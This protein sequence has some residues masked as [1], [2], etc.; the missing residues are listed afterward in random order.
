MSSCC[1]DAGGG[2]CDRRAFLK[3][4]GAGLAAAGAAP[5]RVRRDLVQLLRR[6]D[7]YV[8]EDKGLSTA[9]FARLRERGRPVWYAGDE[10]ETI[11]M[12]VGG[13]CA[14]QLY[15]LGDG[16]LGCWDLANEEAN[17]GY[18]RV[19]YRRGRS[20]RL[21]VRGGDRLVP[22]TAP[23]Q[24]FLLRWRPDGAGGALRERRLDRE[25]FPGVR[26]RGEYPLGFV[27]YRHDDCPLAAELT[28]F[29]PFVPLRAAD[30]SFPATVLRWRLRND[31][32]EPLEVE[33]T[34]WLENPVLLR[35]RAGRA[36]R[37]VQEEFHRR[38]LR[39]L[40][41]RAEEPPPAAEE[42]PPLLFADF[43]GADYGDWEVSGEAFG[44]GPARGTLPNQQPVDGYAGQGLVNSFLG[45]DDRLQGRLRSPEFRIERPW[46]SLLVGGGGHEGRTEVR[47]LVGD[48]I[49]RRARGENRE[50][51]E[52]RNWDVA[53][54]R[55]RS[56]RIE[57]VDLESGGWG[58]INVDR[59]EFRDAPAP[60]GGGPL[61]EQPDFGQVVLAPLGPGEPRLDAA[62][63]RATASLRLAPGEERETVFVLAWHFPNLRNAGRPVGRSYAAAFPDAVAVAAHLAAE[64][65]R[66]EAATRRWHATFYDSTLP[67]WLLDRIG[68]TVSILATATCQRWRD[69]RFWGWEGAGCC[70]GTCGHVWNYAH[71][72][73]RLFPELERSV[74]ERQDFSPDGGFIPETGEIRFRGEGWGA[75]AGDAQAGYVLKALREHQCAPD[76]AFLTRVWPAVRQ[77]LEFLIGQDGGAEADGLLEGLQHNTYDIDYW[78]A[79]TM[80]GSLY[81]AALRAGEEM[82]RLQGDEAFAARCRALF[83]RGSAATMARLWNGEWFEQEVDL[84]EHPD[85]QYADGCLADQLF[86]QGWAHQLGLGYLY[87]AEAVRSA[88]RAVWKYNWAPDVGPQNAAHPP[89][90]VFAEPGEAGLF[91]CTWPK[92]RHLGPR[93]TRYRNEVWTGIEYQVAGH[94]A[95]EGMV[96]EALAICHAVHQRYHPARRNPWNEVECGDHYARAMAAWGVLTGLCGF[97]YD[98][99]AG[100]LGFAPRLGPEDFRAPFT[101]AEG[102]GSY[103]QRIDGERL[104]ARIELRYGRLRLRTLALALPPGRRP[105]SIRWQRLPGPALLKILRF[106]GR[107]LLLGWSEPLELSEPGTLSLEVELRPA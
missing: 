63:G 10:L 49:V 82:A 74:R 32:A 39:G 9:D 8:P 36:V 76:G 7:H 12:P 40:L 13:V 91:T 81:L 11:G 60:A 85:W 72:P 55:G 2:C 29:S 1:G 106:D 16:R 75:W 3:R 79:N 92:G 5:S 73:A 98:G 56:A 59:I 26:F 101:T 94:L 87:P 80:V 107:R 54:F 57:I 27:S 52:V 46:I 51:L 64:L 53:E 84:A 93:S 35:S 62:A 4:S 21:A 44:A 95:W 61:A 69:G 78:G 37:L 38:G 18:G 34:G 22:W 15:L 67:R 17:S 105:D 88:L 28:A 97:E 33:L 100:H 104:E 41:F 25:G 20:A 45:G 102:W 71:A 19:N 30:S 31:G 89:E 77:A 48:E 66:L 65:P 83:E 70:H 23:D 86:G 14:G 99:P 47:L 103:A 43:E 42:R 50:R 6:G 90:R 96:D 58:H 68:S 24:G